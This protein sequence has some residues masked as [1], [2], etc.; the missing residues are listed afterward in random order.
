MALYEWNVIGHEKAIEYLERQ[1][2]DYTLSHALLFVGPEH[3]GK[4]SILKTLARILQCDKNF[5]R[6]C[7]ACT[8]IENGYHIDTIIIADDGSSIKIEQI[9]EIINRLSMTPQSPCKILLLEN[10]WRLTEEAANSLLKILEEPYPK[11]HFFFTASSL[12]EVLPTIQ[13]RMSIFK[14]IVP[15]RKQF[16]RFLSGKFPGLKEES[17]RELEVLSLE[18]PGAMIRLLENPEQL[19]ARKEHYERVKRFCVSFSTVSRFGLIRELIQELKDNPSIILEF[20]GMMTSFLRHLLFHGSPTEQ[21]MATRILPKTVEA[22]E[23]L[24]KNVN[25]RLLL[26][27]LALNFNQGETYGFPL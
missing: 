27:N 7:P 8:Q 13:S 2:R 6:T 25:A 18:K 15:P 26:E 20:L 10:I 23:L 16:F 9:R 17:F 19:E 24:R 3:I 22:Y 1:L 21:S 11:T 4:F 14:L 12:R 5:C